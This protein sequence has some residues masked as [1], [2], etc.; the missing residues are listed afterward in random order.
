VAV[1]RPAV[2]GVDDGGG[3]RWAELMVVAVFVHVGGR[4]TY[5]SFR[6]I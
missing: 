3:L 4:P 1:L 6:L 5:I 2:V